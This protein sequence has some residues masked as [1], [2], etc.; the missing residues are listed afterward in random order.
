MKA[1]QSVPVKFS[2]SGDQG[3][4]I[5]ADGSPAW[6]PCGS[7]D[8]SRAAGTLGYN[9]SN[10]RYTYLA[11]TAKSWAGTCRD[12]VVTLADGTVHKLRFTFTK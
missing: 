4:A 5:F 6:A 3:A 9:A 8:T 11:T 7:S 12:L 10:D 1:G 2:L